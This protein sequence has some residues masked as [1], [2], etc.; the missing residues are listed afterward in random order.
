MSRGK[1][2]VALSGGV[3]S[4]VTAYLL[5]KQDYEIIAVFMQNWDDYFGNQPTPVCSS[6]QDWKE[7]QA[8]AQQLDIPLHKVEFI[9]EYWDEVFAN[10]LQDLEKGLTPNPDILCNSVI[11]FNYFVEYVKKN[12][13]VDFIATGHY[14]KILIT[15]DEDSFSN[16][17]HYLTKPKDKE[18]DQTYFL[19]QINCQLLSKLIFPLADLSKKEVRQIAQKADL[20]NAQRKDSTGICFIGERKFEKFLANYFPRKEGEIIDIDNQKTLGKHPGTVYFTIGQRK[21]LGLAGQKNACYVVGKD[22]KRNFIYV[23]SGWD[24]EWLY[25]QWC[26]VKKIN[27]LVKGR[28]LVEWLNGSK[29]TA[30]FRYRQAEVPVKI[31]FLNEKANTQ[32]LKVVF[33]QKQRAITPGQYAVFYYQNICLGGGVITSTEKLNEYSEPKQVNGAGK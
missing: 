29:I 15:E 20:V 21:N 9:R 27:W 18:K 30:K 6:T 19:C 24:N 17:G 3:D 16:S 26:E 14:A 13:V 7:A 1:V 4:A 10:F 8:I 32:N 33:S 11:K 12:F 31:T 25:S 23:A 5:K 2:I 22:Q 28:E